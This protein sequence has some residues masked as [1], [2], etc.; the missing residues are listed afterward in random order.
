M[1]SRQE[2]RT[3]EGWGWRAQQR[4]RSLGGSPAEGEM[5]PGST[6][7]EPLPP[8]ALPPVTGWVVML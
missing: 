5:G 4:G 3:G 7:Q 8:P 6:R 1:R 2:L